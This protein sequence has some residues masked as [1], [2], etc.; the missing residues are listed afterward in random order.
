V[1]Y[2]IPGGVNWTLSVRTLLGQ[3]ILFQQG[4]GQ[5]TLDLSGLPTGTYLGQLDSQEGANQTLRLVVR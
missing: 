3:E 4:Q 2:G 1:L 5:A